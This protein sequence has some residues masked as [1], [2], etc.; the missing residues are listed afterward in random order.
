MPEMLRGLEYT[1]KKCVLTSVTVSNSKHPKPQ[2]SPVQWISA[3]V[4]VCALPGGR[5]S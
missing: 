1:L 4:S 2:A 3:N 5:E